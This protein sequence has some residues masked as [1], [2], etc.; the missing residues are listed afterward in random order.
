MPFALVGV[1][2]LVTASAVGGTLAT[3][4][5]PDT[6][7]AADRAADEATAA[8]RVALERATLRGSVAAA[9]NPVITPANTSYGRVLRADS[10]F[11][12]ALELRMYAAARQA[13]AETP[14]E[15]DRASARVTL[16]A[17]DSPADARRA[18]NRVSVT[19]VA[20]GRVRV[21][22]RNATL[23][24]GLDG[25]V[26]TR[27]TYSPSVV[28][29]APVLSLHDRVAAFDA[30]LDRGA[31]DG[32]GLAR[33]T[34]IRLYP[35]TAARGLAQYGGAPIENVLGNRHVAVATNDALLAVQRA[36]LGRPAVGSPDAVERAYALTGARDALTTARR[37]LRGRASRI[38]EGRNVSLPTKPWRAVEPPRS[39]VSAAATADDALVGYVDGSGS[40]SLS[41]TLARAYHFDARRVVAATRLDHDVTEGSPPEGWTRVDAATARET[42]VTDAGGGESWRERVTVPDGVRATGGESRRVVRT[43]TIRVTW[44][45][46]SATR[47]TTRVERTVA[48]VSVA[49]A[50]KSGLLPGV[51]E[52]PVD[53]DFPA[54]VRAA[55]EDALLRD[56]GSVD[57]LARRAASGDGVSTSASVSVTPPEGVRDRASRELAGLRDRIANLSTSTPVSGAGLFGAN[58]VAALARRLDD[59][60]RALVAAPDRYDGLA[61]RAVVA[62]RAGYV[63]ATADRL[64]DRAG[65][66]AD[67]RGALRETVTRLG[68]WIPT[69]ATTR[70]VPETVV[71]D[72]RASPRYLTLARGDDGTAPL[73]ARNVNLFAIPYGEAADAI[74]STAVESGKRAV[75]LATAA[76][77]LAVASEAG[78]ASQL[79]NAAE[80]AGEDVRTRMADVVAARTDASHETAESVV[81]AANGRWSTPA[82]RARAATNGSLARVVLAVADR[83]G[84]VD[85]RDRVL[86]AAA[87]RRTTRDARVADEAGVPEDVVRAARRT[88]HAELDAALGDASSRAARRALGKRLSALPAGLPVA[89]VP[90]YW[91]ATANAWVVSVRGG[92]ERFAVS[93]GATPPGIGGDYTYVRRDDSI[94]FDVDGDGAREVLGRNTAVE[95]SFDTV[96]VAAVP[97]GPRG[98]G[99]VDGNVDERSPGWGV[100]ETTTGANASGRSPPRP[101]P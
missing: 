12:D 88:A 95:F 72:V 40:P 48:R 17:V 28:V 86:L 63:D 81:S 57:A 13:F 91:Y 53:G 45:N 84:L 27:R 56:A 35:Y 71:D 94:G 39:D 5:A 74:V 50:A 14:V 38:L 65:A 78:D 93:A 15:T 22:L 99:D 69:G 37:D 18:I 59:R 87:L 33:A 36:T 79:S 80:D 9:R 16:P 8:A 19:E 54:R 4:D 43:E 21:Q 98:V 64:D 25:R 41:G 24:V 47:T 85:G 29:D 68:G 83:R 66:A 49:F 90:G 67:V 62:A 101:R 55:V 44:T 82:A 76:D 73:A 92:Y 10:A 23:R 26:V 75:G 31:L 61:D 97:L 58:P 96:V 60:R 1:V 46:G 89:P 42:T 32:P 11:E 7:N 34:T 6:T 77:V 100:N 3:R 70:D 52:R 2:L 51:P 30:S 20:P